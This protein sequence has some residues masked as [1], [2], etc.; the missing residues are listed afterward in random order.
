MNS[1]RFAK[2]MHM[3]LIKLIIGLLSM[4]TVLTGCATEL[5][6]T[7]PRTGQEYVVPERYAGVPGVKELAELCAK[8][9]GREVKQVVYVDGYFDGYTQT[10]EMDCWDQVAGS[11]LNYLEIQVKSPRSFDFIKEPGIW[12]IYKTDKEDPNCHPKIR[13][14]ALNSKHY[15]EFNKKYCLALQKNDQLESQYEAFGDP[16]DI[17]LDNEYQSKIYRSHGGYRDRFTKEILGTE[18]YFQLSPRHNG[19]EPRTLPCGSA[20]VKINF[21]GSLQSEVL[22][23]K[24]DR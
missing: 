3:K 24:G 4:L 16:K 7:D 2:D 14:Y 9:A 20:G 12:K 11:E 17:I 19:L 5:K 1:Q 21:N 8:E 15:T 22:K 10:C 18:T 6:V 13:V 23:P